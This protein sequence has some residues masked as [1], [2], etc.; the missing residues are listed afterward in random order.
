MTADDDGHD[1]G[2]HDDY[3]DDRHNVGHHDDDDD[4]RDGY[5]IFIIRIM[6]DIVC[7]AMYR[8]TP[9]IAVASGGPL[10]TVLHEK[11]GFLCE[12]VMVI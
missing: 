9:V 2:E 10:E 7:Q 6:M 3:D 5:H 4:G 1:D 12:Q 8:C 11:T